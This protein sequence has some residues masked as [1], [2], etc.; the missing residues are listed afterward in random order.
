LLDSW[1]EIVA[2]INR[3]NRNLA[4][5]VRDCPPVAVEEDLVTLCARSRFHKDQLESDQA[6][7]LV[8]T[9]ISE[10]FGQRC[11][12]RCLLT[13]D[14]PTEGTSEDDLQQLT[15]DPVIKAGLELG[16]QIGTVR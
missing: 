13:P 5:V 16:G 4:A 6:K 10:S 1:S 7:E 9:A 12:I 8:G 15:E 14:T 11:R 3:S 2:I